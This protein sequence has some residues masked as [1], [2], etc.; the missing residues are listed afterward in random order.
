VNLRPYQQQA[1]TDLRLAYRGGARAPLLCL[2]TGGGKTCILASI[3]A[4]AAARG[5]NVLILV[6]RRELIHQTASKLAWVGLEHG[7]IAAG[8]RPQMHGCRSHRCKRSCAAYAHQPGS[9]L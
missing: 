2:P 6:H 7:I 1:I 5:R 4:Q 3:A 9:P 8:F